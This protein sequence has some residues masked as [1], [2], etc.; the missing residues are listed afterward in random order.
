[1]VIIIKTN[2]S[3][4]IEDSIVEVDP[5]LFFQRLIVFIQRSV[6]SART[7]W[8][9]MLHIFQDTHY[10]FDGESLLQRLPQ[11]IGRRFD[12]ICQFSKYYLLN[13]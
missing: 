9:Y 5:Q 4:N 12:E 2:A 7:L 11:T 6:G 1:M 10:V 8:V 13:N 3:V